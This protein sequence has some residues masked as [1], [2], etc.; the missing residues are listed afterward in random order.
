MSDVKPTNTGLTLIRKERWQGRILIKARLVIL[1][2]YQFYE[3]GKAKVAHVVNIAVWEEPMSMDI[4]STS[5]DQ[6]RDS[7]GI[8]TQGL[9]IQARPF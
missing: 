3:R 7:S 2:A 8:K 4:G 5:K 6:H 1:N 9:R